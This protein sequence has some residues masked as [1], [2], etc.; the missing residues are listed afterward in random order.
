MTTEQ[1][2][3]EFVADGAEDVEVRVRRPRAKKTEKGGPVDNSDP[4]P[5]FPDLDK[6]S[7]NVITYIEVY[8]MSPPGDGY[9]GT[10]PP[11]ATKDYLG[12]RFGNGYY[13]LEAC[14]ADGECLR[15]AQGINIA[16]PI[17]DPGVARPGMVPGLFDGNMAEKLLDRLATEH[18][19]AS[20]RSKDLTTE[21]IQATK[22]QASTYAT[23]IR[24]DSKE[25]AA[26][27][28]DFFQAQQSAQ[29]GFFSA[30][31]T[32]LQQL[33]SMN[34]ESMQAGFTQTFQMMQLQHAQSLQQNNPA[35]LFQLFERGMRMGADMNGG[36]DPFSTVLTAGVKGLSELKELA[37]LQKGLTPPKLTNGAP[38]TVKR[39]GPKNT[40]KPGPKVTREDVL[41][42]AKLKRLALAKGQDF[43]A[44]LRQAQFALGE[45][46]DDAAESTTDD[47][48]SE[49]ETRP[50]NVGDSGPSH[51]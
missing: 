35:F 19:K 20:Q 12:K 29:Q 13:N 4:V 2:E 6:N 27:D 8:R 50:S 17:V 46:P 1:T 21:T 34:M 7:R 30:M 28:R 33:H 5:L 37:M 45:M 25:R 11:N 40:A 42:L 32:Q 14:N 10:I 48:E 44:M 43:D 36:D 24:E 9:K 51:G 31:I 38:A 16:I 23:M 47:S 39:K 22:E 26:R 3:E 41:A 18:E 15:R 49:E